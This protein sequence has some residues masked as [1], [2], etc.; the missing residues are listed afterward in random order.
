M[1]HRDGTR[2]A[3]C[4]WSSRG[5]RA[6][7]APSGAHQ[8]ARLGSAAC[9]RRRFHHAAASAGGA[10]RVYRIPVYADRIFGNAAWWL[11]SSSFV[12]ALLA[13]GFA[14]G[15]IHYLLDRATFRLPPHRGEAGRPRPAAVKIVAPIAALDATRVRILRRRAWA[16][17]A[18]AT[19]S[20][21]TSDRIAVP[22]MTGFGRSGEDSRRF[23]DGSSPTARSRR[24]VSWNARNA[25]TIPGSS[26]SRPCGWL[27]LERNQG[28]GGAGTGRSVNQLRQ[29]RLDFEEEEH[30]GVPKQELAASGADRDAAA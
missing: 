1:E 13:L 20:R 19:A 17:R 10:G 12:P 4:F 6:L 7:A 25:G 22:R 30:N 29:W 16:N 9:A 5:L 24:S 18:G 3:R 8:P 21:R 26:S 2:L 11:R 23:M 28:Q 14:S 15:F 27:L